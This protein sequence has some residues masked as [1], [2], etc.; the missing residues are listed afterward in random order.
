VAA[1]DLRNG[2]LPAAYPPIPSTSYTSLRA[3]AKW[4]GIDL[5]LF[6]QNLFNTQPKLSVIDNAGVQSPL[7]Q[8]IT[9]RPRTVG[10]TATYR[11]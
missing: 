6:A 1:Q 11:Y 2:G 7:F 9:W 4:A 3:G 5:S 10:V 8:A